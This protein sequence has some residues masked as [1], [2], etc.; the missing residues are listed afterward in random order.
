MQKRAGLLYLSKETKRIFLILND[1][2][3]TVP[4]VSI[5]GPFLES[6]SNLLDECSC[7]KIVPIELYQSADS[8]FEFNTFVCL[9]DKEF[10][11]KT[12][13][14]ISWAS[15]DNLPKN[16]HP[17]IKTTLTNNYTKQKIK[18]ILDYYYI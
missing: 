4:T 2:K 14:T 11:P 8:G 7:G 12:M 3:W 17:G 9:V 10:L 6:I 15:L 16:L 5:N 1:F 13:S 18:T